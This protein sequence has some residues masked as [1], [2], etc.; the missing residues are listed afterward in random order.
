MPYL[1]SPN[2]SATNA[3]VLP[4]TAP[5]GMRKQDVCR[6]G[7]GAFL[8]TI[9]FSEG[10]MPVK[11]DASDRKSSRLTKKWS[12]LVPSRRVWKSGTSLFGVGRRPARQPGARCPTCPSLARCS[13]PSRTLRAAQGHGGPRRGGPSLG[14]AQGHALD[15]GSARRPRRIH[16]GTEKRFLTAPK[17]RHRRRRDGSARPTPN[18][19]EAPFQ[20]EA[21]RKRRNGFDLVHPLVLGTNSLLHT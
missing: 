10:L 19:E 2:H 21:R 8:A 1:R 17:K 12:A 18:S 20:I 7:H 15:R 3:Q 16:A 13:P 6:P 4:V 5:T 11:R 14:Q 9:L